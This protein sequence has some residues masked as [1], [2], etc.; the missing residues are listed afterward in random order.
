MQQVGELLPVGSIVLLKG[1]TKKTMIMGVL[2]TD[3]EHP[4]T[5]YDYMGI[6]YPEGYM[7]EESVYLFQHENI[8]DIAE[9]VGFRNFTQFYREFKKFYHVTPREYR[10]AYASYRQKDS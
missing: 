2:Q 4:E 9:S 5:V 8:N 6:P 10:L 3:E 1:G 7:G